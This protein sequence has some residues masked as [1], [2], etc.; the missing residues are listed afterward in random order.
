MPRNPELAHL[1]A[2]ELRRR[3]LIAIERRRKSEMAAIIREEFERELEQR[4]ART[5][6]LGTRRDTLN[7]LPVTLSVRI[8]SELSERLQML[9]SEE[10]LPVS[11]VVRRILT[12][13][14]ID[15]PGGRHRKPSDPA[16]GEG[17]AA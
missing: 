10:L 5:A 1:S 16:A 9:A 6:T 15:Q 17:Y 2:E 7:Y 3:K 4:E 12:A 8:D 11:T 14:L 13:A